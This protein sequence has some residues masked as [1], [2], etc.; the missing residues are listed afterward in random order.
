LQPEAAGDLLD[1]VDPNS[2]G[3]TRGISQ[4]SSSTSRTDRSISLDR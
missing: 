2:K 3:A 4:R 1:P